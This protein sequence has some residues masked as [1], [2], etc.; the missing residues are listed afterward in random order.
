MRKSL[1]LTF[2][3]LCTILICSLAFSIIVVINKNSQIEKLTKQNNQLVTQLQT[4]ESAY[5]ELLN[6]Y[7]NLLNEYSKLETN[8]GSLN[9]TYQSLLQNYTGLMVEYEKVLTEYTELKMSYARLNETYEQLLHNYTEL[10]EDLRDYET[11]KNQYQQLSQEYQ[12]L[13]S[14]Y[15]TLYSA[16]YS[17]LLSNETLT[18][19]I[20]ELEQWLAEDNTDKINYVEWDFVCGDFAVMLSLHAKLKHWDM[21]IVG[22]LGRDS[23]GNEFNHAFNAIRCQEG[24]VYI[25]PQNDS[26]FHG[27]IREGEWYYHPGFGSIYVETFIIIVLYQPPL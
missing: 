14:E 27:P 21:G 13:E 2:G 20:E 9:I 25:E 7:N 8:Y 24:I 17:P 1:A 16:F 6:E 18:P 3:I 11:L 5:T 10:Q 23:Y 22:V 12:Q 26:I 4:I 19:T 15:E